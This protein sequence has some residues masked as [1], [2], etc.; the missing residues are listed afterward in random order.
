MRGIRGLPRRRQLWALYLGAAILP[1][2]LA[3][4]GE[5]AVWTACIYWMVS[6]AA[7]TSGSVVLAYLVRK[8]RSEDGD[9]HGAA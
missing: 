5:V 1:A 2:A 7:V 6:V 3:G 8:D 9:R 4:S